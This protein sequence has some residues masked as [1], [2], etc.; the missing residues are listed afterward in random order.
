MPA[1]RAAATTARVWVASQR[2]PKLLPPRPTTETVRPD[3][4]SWRY[5]MAAAFLHAAGAHGRRK[6]SD[7]RH[8]QT[9]VRV[10]GRCGEGEGRRRWNRTLGYIWTNHRKLE[11]VIPTRRLSRARDRAEPPGS[12]RCRPPGR[13]CG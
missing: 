6:G 8:G 2:E 3:R 9:C 12:S 4:P 10:R 7:G 11:G 13:R 5:L 1:S